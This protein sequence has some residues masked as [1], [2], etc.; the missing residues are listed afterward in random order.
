MTATNFRATGPMLLRLS[1]LKREDYDLWVPRHEG[2]GEITSQEFV[3]YIRTLIQSTSFLE[4][5]EVSSEALSDTLRKVERGIPVARK[6]LVR[7][8]LS[9]T[10][11]LLRATG[12]PTPFGLHAGVV[13][14]HTASTTQVAI[15][16]P[17]AKTVRF[18]AGWFTAQV[19]QWIKVPEIRKATTAVCNDL[20]FMRGDRLVLP[21]G[22]AEAKGQ[23]VAIRCTPFVAWVRENAAEPTAWSSLLDSA[24]VAFPE[25]GRAR[26]DDLLLRLAQHEILITSLSPDAI[27]ENFL[28]RV[29][30]TLAQAPSELVQLRELEAALRAYEAAAVGEGGSAWR[31]AVELCKESGQNHGSVAQV[32]MSMTAHVAITERVTE[33]IERYASTLWSMSPETPVYSHMREYREAFMDKYGEHGAV[34]LPELIDPHTGLGFPRGYQNPNAPR[35]ARLIAYET[36]VERFR[37]GRRLDRVAALA[38][39]GILSPDREIRLSA[40]DIA[41]LSV[42]RTASPPEALELSFQVLADSPGALDAGDFLLMASPMI[43]STTAGSSMGRFAELTGITSGLRDLV[44]RVG[45]EGVIV[46]QLGFRPRNPRALNVTQ[47]PELL[48]H[49]IP[50]GQFHDR[51]S[52][53]YIDWRQLVVAAD[54]R[55]L[56]LVHE[57][58]GH[59]VCPVVPHMLNLEAQAPNVARFLAE[60]KHTGDDQVLQVWDW[61]GFA[62]APWLPRVRLGKVILSPLSWRPSI[63]MRDRVHASS[64]WSETVARWRDDFAV[65][66]RVCVTSADLTYEIDLREPF[67]RELLRRDMAKG[68]VKVTEC[69]RELGSYGWSDGRANE[70]VV[71]LS[72]RPP[73]V[74]EAS[75]WPAPDALE[76]PR[77]TPVV[78][79]GPGGDWFYVQI[80]AVPAVHDDVICALDD[81]M[82]ISDGHW[83]KWYFV[84]FLHP[85]P[86]IRLRV[87]LTGDDA[88]R[89][90]LRSLED[91][92]C[93]HLIR[94]FRVCA[95]EP[96][97][98]RYGGPDAMEPAEGVFGLDSQTVA[99]ELRLLRAARTTVPRETL[100]V[101]NYGLLLD[102]LEGPDWPS[103]VGAMFKKSTGGS[104]TRATIQQASELLEPG[105][106]ASRLEEV[107][108]LPGLTA[109][110]Q[111]SACIKE[112]SEALRDDE[113]RTGDVAFR[114]RILLSFLHMQHNRLIGVDRSS[115]ARTLTLLGHVARAYTD[116]QRY[117][118]ASR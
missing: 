109:M 23:E 26:L 44:G 37:D 73:T 95:Y 59:E 69:I 15:S 31:R 94:E 101:A 67:H 75:K 58:T 96:E 25:A 87:R 45:R 50:V 7:A 89:M 108:K 91:M 110:W 82:R 52:P 38:Q 28:A 103:W 42:T 48:P 33:E 81:M 6:Q 61:G 17:G 20:C 1:A 93:S 97:I 49:H 80:S 9:L 70:I 88:G 76:S 39:Q 14:L 32:D 77:I 8:A 29:R 5:V 13:A 83:S 21:Y 102:A 12:R 34:P 115:E 71:P 60:I 74:E 107:L 22:R 16:G 18:D 117:R 100:V 111:T 11:Y 3:E 2:D 84:R 118:G 43:G 63:A 46:A 51:A 86:H 68:S 30:H 116:R 112:M 99:A 4:A 66:D 92:R 78:H 79:H 56:R 72:S 106:V 41:G 40:S 85:E 104:V 24:V 54:G 27:D 10:R 105:A 113:S 57:P 35:D 114:R 36:D 47:V 64:E 90:L 62:R 65:P 19:K 55:R 53:G 98:G